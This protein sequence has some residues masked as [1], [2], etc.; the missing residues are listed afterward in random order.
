MY[1]NRSDLCALDSEDLALQFAGT[2]LDAEERV[3][4]VCA[5]LFVWNHVLEIRFIVSGS[6]ERR[7]QVYLFFMD[8]PDTEAR[9]G[10]N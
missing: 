8:R 10:C 4:K 3:E 2:N 7:D 5:Q 6:C 1:P 9:A